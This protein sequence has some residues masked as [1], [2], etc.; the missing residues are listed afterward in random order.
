MAPVPESNVSPGGNP[1]ALHAYGVVPPVAVS[2]ALYAVP[3]VAGG[4]DVV[5]ME[6]GPPPPAAL[7]VILSG[8]AAVVAGGVELSTAF[9]VKLLVPVALGVP[10]IAPVAGDKLSPVGS[11]PLAIDHVIVP[12][13]PLEV[14]IVL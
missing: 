10:E 4:K 2:V 11:E 13:P 5:V 14:S 3:C 8:I 9:T 7:T 6:I 1:L 12:V